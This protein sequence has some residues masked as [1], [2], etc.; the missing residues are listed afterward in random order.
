[1]PDFSATSWSVSCPRAIRVDRVRVRREAL[2]RVRPVRAERR[3]HV[4]GRLGP[5]DVL[6]AE[7]E[8]VA[9]DDADDEPEHGQPPA[10]DE[11]VE[12]AA[13]VDLPLGVEIRLGRRSRG[14][15]ASPGSLATG[16]GTSSANG[17]SVPSSPSVRTRSEKK[18]VMTMPSRNSPTVGSGCS[19]FASASASSG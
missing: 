14:G 12:V 13:E 18:R 3:A 2:E 6:A 10:R 1:M 11:R 5:I 7:R 15:H 16:S 19:P 17:S 9:D 8:Q 4:D